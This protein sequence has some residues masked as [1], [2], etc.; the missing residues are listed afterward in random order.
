VYVCGAAEN[1]NTRALCPAVTARLRVPHR[2]ANSVYLSH[3]LLASPSYALPFLRTTA[4]FTSQDHRMQMTPSILVRDLHCGHLFDSC[5]YI[6]CYSYEN[7]IFRIA[8]GGITLLK[9]AT[10]RVSWRWQP[11]EIHS[12]YLIQLTHF[13]VS[14][15]RSSFQSTQEPFSECY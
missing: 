3:I 7:A 12:S 4:I 14:Q 15:A 8:T 2:D 9:D 6:L 1:S 10:G 11:P 13:E 5:M